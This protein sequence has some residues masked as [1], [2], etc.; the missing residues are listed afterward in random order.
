MQ[1]NKED[2]DKNQASYSSHLVAIKGKRFIDESRQHPVVNE[3]PDRIGESSED[4][5]NLFDRFTDPRI[6]NGA[7]GNFRKYHKGFI[8][9]FGRAPSND[10]LA[11]MSASISNAL[12][13]IG[14]ASADNGPTSDL[15][16]QLEMIVSMETAI[17]LNCF[18]ANNTHVIHSTQKEA[19]Y[20]KRTRKA[21]TDR[22]GIKKD[23]DISMN[24]TSGY[25]QGV[26]NVSTGYDGAGAAHAAGVPNGVLTTLEFVGVG[27]KIKSN[28][29]VWYGSQMIASDPTQSGTLSGTYD[30]NGTPKAVSGTYDP[31]TGAFSNLQVAGG[32]TL[33]PALPGNAGLRVKAESDWERAGKEI[34]P[35]TTYEYFEE[36]I[37]PHWNA[38]STVTSFM[39][40]LDAI[41]AFGHNLAAMGV[42]ELAMLFVASANIKT[43]QE[44]NFVATTQA[45]EDLYLQPKSGFAYDPSTYERD[46]CINF[47]NA[48]SK[49]ISI[50][51]NRLGS[52]DYIYVDELCT[53]FLDRLSVHGPGIWRPRQ[54]RI[55]ENMKGQPH[56]YG[57]LGGNTGWD[58]YVIPKGSV[59]DPTKLV[60]NVAQPILADWEFIMGSK[61]NGTPFQSP[62]VTGTFRSPLPINIAMTNEFE[63]EDI[64]VS[65]EYFHVRPDASNWFIRGNMNDS[66][67]P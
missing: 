7:R 47:F 58:I 3:E 25:N 55:N 62:I 10:V 51:C 40:N 65:E 16:P 12:D 18:N 23:Q 41:T 46:A 43:V 49:Q 50:N 42:A 28:M 36:S 30:D 31:A 33:L 54:T 39:A 8:D 45:A 66:E 9:Q 34:L 14:E 21:L 1:S 27:H 17:R 22:A 63:K 64:L 52:G 37:K 35:R 38:G 13:R 44:Q 48:L 19:K 4:L 59:I 61:G 56:Y 67:L 60:A 57:R 53:N 15:I 20:F 29:E 26:M 6:R 32:A 2:F 5:P 24:L 11:G